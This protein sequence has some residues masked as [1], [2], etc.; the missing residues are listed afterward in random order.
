MAASP[1]A[2]ALGDVRGS[3]PLVV[4]LSL[5]L[6]TALE[7]L[8]VLA[9]AASG[10]LEGA[11]PFLVDLAQKVPWG[12]GVCTGIWLGLQL[13][14]GNLLVAAAAGLIAAPIAA[15]LLRA[16]AEGAHALA[17]IEAPA[18]PAL[19]SVAAVK[20]VEYACLGLLLAWLGRRPW[21]RAPHY[22]AAGL[23]VAIPFGLA[24]L[25][26]SEGA[27]SAALD[28]SGLLAWAVDEL[29]FP[30]GCALIVFTA[31]RARRAATS[32]G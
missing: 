11:G 24:L 8:H 25:A 7:I 10:G 32:R 27:A 29:L 14:H 4:A 23:T 31:D 18:G 6:V 3:T 9:A 15:M 2:G 19:L 21:A 16:V 12:V 26:L 17:F 22:A 1:T 30:V 28:A 5:A 20:G 13:G